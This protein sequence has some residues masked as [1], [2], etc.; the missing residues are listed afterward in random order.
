MTSNEALRDRRERSLRRVRRLAY[1]LDEAIPIPV[2]N[3]RVGLD[4]IIGLIP[5]VGDAT[6]LVLSSAVVG[7]A[8]RVGA[9]RRIIVRMLGII[10]IDFV[11]GLVPVAGD[12]F[13]IYWQANSRN[14]GLLEG[15]LAAETESSEND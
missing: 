9:P 10:G 5:G 8:V 3:V 13:D 14:L 15:W 6:G 11:V 12:V 1:W 7:E 4:S 2:I